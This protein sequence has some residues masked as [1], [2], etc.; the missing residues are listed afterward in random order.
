MNEFDIVK[1]CTTFGLLKDN[2][3]QGFGKTI[4][5]YATLFN[6]VVN[7]HETDLNKI[8][9]E[10]KTMQMRNQGELLKEMYTNSYANVE[11]E[12]V[13]SK[14]HDLQK[15]IDSLKQ[16]KCAPYGSIF[17]LENFLHELKY[18]ITKAEEAIMDI[19][20]A[21]KPPQTQPGGAKKIRK[22]KTTPKP[23]TKNTLKTKAKK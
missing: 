21:P 23:K 8:D 17:V 19:K 22:A 5:D 2:N 3:N 9:Q 6:L 16:S 1:F 11:H 7:D 12:D 15:Y 18:F 13:I 20:Y 10:L 14:L 4:N